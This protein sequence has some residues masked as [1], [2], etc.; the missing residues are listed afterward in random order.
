MHYKSSRFIPSRPNFIYENSYSSHRVVLR[1]LFSYLENNISWK[2]DVTLRVES[3]IIRNKPSNKNTYNCMF[4]SIKDQSLL[5]CSQQKCCPFTNR[6]GIETTSS[7]KTIQQINKSNWL[8][9]PQICIKSTYSYF[10][11]TLS[12]PVP[13]WLH[14][15]CISTPISFKCKA[16]KGLMPPLWTLTAGSSLEPILLTWFYWNVCMDK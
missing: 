13:C 3:W 8:R 5:K 12:F 4:I 9:I 14:D 7:K 16:I 1:N 11:C 15:N 2:S 10:R 6:D